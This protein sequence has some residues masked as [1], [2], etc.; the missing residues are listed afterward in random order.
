MPLAGTQLALKNAAKSAALSALKAS[1]QPKVPEDAPLPED[2]LDAIAA[3][4]AEAVVVA[5][6]HIL[7]NAQVAPGIP[8]ATAGSPAAQTGST[9]SVGTLL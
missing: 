8:V 5:L 4:I 6:N 3:A 1:Q 9:V 2:N 7:A